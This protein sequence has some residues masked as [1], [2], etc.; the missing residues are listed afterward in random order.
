MSVAVKAPSPGVRS[1]Y[2]GGI[3]P[4]YSP[5]LAN[6]DLAPVPAEKRNWRTYNLFAMWMSDVH[7]VGGYA[8]AA[9]LF[10]TGL[11]GAQVLLSM[12]VG[13]GLVYWFITLVGKPSQRLGA[14][15]PVVARISFGV[16]GANLPALVRALIAIVWYGVQTYLASVSL[17]IL[18][19][20]FF[21][22]LRAYADNANGFVG[23][24]ALGW[25]CYIVVWA[26]QLTLFYHGMDA[27]RRFIDFTGPSVYIVMFG[28]AI[29]IVSKAGLGNIEMT[30]PSAKMTSGD[31]VYE[32]LKVAALVVGYFAALLLNFGDF[33]RYTPSEREM[34]EGNLWGLPINW[35]LFSIVTVVITSGT[36]TV[37]G[38]MIMD[39]IA[40]VG[41]IDSMTAVVL[42]SLTFIVATL[43]INIV[44]NF[45]A[46]AFDLANV[47]PKHINFRKGGLIAGGI[48]L[49]TLPWHF[50]NSPAAISYFVGMVGGFLGPLYGI[51]MA[52]YYW[53]KKQQVVR[54]DLYSES[55]SG[56]YFYRNGWNPTALM[57]LFPAVILSAI[58]SLVPDIEHIL[59]PFNWFIS[60]AVA[61]VLYRVFSKSV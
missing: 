1:G 13:I 57:A 58:I 31:V 4:E 48:V 36:V 21:P 43:G 50:Y 47:A 38:E 32:M 40:L 55:P 29:W 6:E 5:R 49:F 9:G 20:K 35:M 41:R 51:M 8:F 39:P 17:Q 22:D 15:F 34:H 27:I 14:P 46:P 28:L 30:L 60:A 42:G 45:V 53:V 33:S 56:R 23:L 26:L 24:S 7:S 3:K 59:G 25:F 16:F 54:D 19:L 37:F 2:E 52:D 61:A 11:S 12:L 10:A 44:A 18:L